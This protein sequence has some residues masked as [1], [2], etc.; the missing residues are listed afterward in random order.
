MGHVTKYTVLEL[1]ERLNSVW[2]GEPQGWSKE[3]LN[4]HSVLI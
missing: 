2:L 4:T 3:E 1:N